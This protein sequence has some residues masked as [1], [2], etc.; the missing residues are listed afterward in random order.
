MKHEEDK[1]QQGCMEEWDK[2]QDRERDTEKCAYKQMRESCVR[3]GTNK[4]KKQDH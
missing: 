4:W 3:I 1:K 2:D